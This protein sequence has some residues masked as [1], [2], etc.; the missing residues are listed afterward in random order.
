MPSRVA[1]SKPKSSYFRSKL[2]SLFYTPIIE[3]IK[4]GDKLNSKIK[5][6]K[7]CLLAAFV[8]GEF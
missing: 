8:K 2:W 5:H 3:P 4:S 1:P 7:T 6:I